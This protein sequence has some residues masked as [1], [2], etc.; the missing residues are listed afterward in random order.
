MEP[1]GA[2]GFEADGYR[3]G[4]GVCLETFFAQFATLTTHFE[5]AEGCSRVEDII[6]IDPDGSGSHPFGE[7]VGATDVFGPNSS[8]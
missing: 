4:L 1:E 6:A 7:F 3:L 5:T 8:R 2:L